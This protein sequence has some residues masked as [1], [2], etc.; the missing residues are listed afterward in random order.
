MRVKLGNITMD[1]PIHRDEETTLALVERINERLRAIEDQSRVIDS[2]QFALLAA[3]AFAVE[4]TER[5]EEL[6][7]MA[8]VFEEIDGELRGILRELGA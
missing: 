4:S 7:E 3:Y 6:G 8:S 5:A 1:V 2:Q